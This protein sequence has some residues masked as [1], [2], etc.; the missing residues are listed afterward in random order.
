MLDMNKCARLAK[1]SIIECLNSSYSVIQ[2]SGSQQILET[3]GCKLFGHGGS[4]SF[5]WSV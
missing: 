1:G 5:I 2:M 3:R 4:S